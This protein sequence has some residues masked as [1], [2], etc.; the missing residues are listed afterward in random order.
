MTEVVAKPR[1][2]GKR[3]WACS[4]PGCGVTFTRHES[5][6]ADPDRPHCSSAC[7]GRHRA[8][9]RFSLD[10]RAQAV[11]RYQQ[12]EHTAHL[13]KA[14][15]VSGDA[16]RRALREAG[17]TPDR[18][19]SG[20]ASWVARTRVAADEG[21]L[22]SGFRWCIGCRERKPMGE[23]YW[24]SEEKKTRQRRCKP[25]HGTY[26]RTGANR[27]AA[28]RKAAYGLSPRRFDEMWQEQGGRCAIC[29][30]ELD[31]SVRH[32]VHV[33][34]CHFDGDVRG[35]LCGRCNTG[36]G[37]FRDDPELLMAAATYLMADHW[38]PSLEPG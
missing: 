33:D 3:A 27:K 14:Y 34:H 32:G 22:E 36:L 16:I 31:E 24:R 13:A 1:G 5:N 20:H 2:K 35:L 30:E 17:V 8:L 19:R 23:Y 28:R 9:L 10:A 4:A 25:C 37:H 38:H 15:N 12:G 11:K 26:V 6:V 7:A 29:P 21:D 18:S